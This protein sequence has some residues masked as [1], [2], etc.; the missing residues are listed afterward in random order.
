MLQQLELLTETV[1]A[2]DSTEK[3]ADLIGDREE[4]IDECL[5][6]VSR[7]EAIVHDVRGFA[8]ETSG[9]LESVDLNR[10]VEDALRIATARSRSEVEVEKNFDELMPVLCVPG[11]IVQVLVNLL[12]NAIHATDG[13][14][15][16]QLSTW[17]HAGDVWICIEDDGCGIAHDVIPRVFDPFFTTKPV[18]HGT[19]LGL[20][21]SHHIIRNHGGDVR[22]ESELGRGA[23]FT[24]A[25]PLDPGVSG[26]RDLFLNG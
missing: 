20:A 17:Q 4:L 22:V 24:V 8:A 19:G 16:V 6:G 21:I 13:R 5:E 1:R 2:C 23:R 15:R 25:L 3:L 10:L 14:G 9:R 7:I 11:E 12:I 18:G 26:D